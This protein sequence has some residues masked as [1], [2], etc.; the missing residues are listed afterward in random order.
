MPP[1]ILVIASL[2][3]QLSWVVFVQCHPRN[4]QGSHDPAAA[5]RCAA[6]DVGRG[7]PQCLLEGIDLHVGA[8]A[9]GQHEE[10]CNLRLGCET[11]ECA[12]GACRL[13]LVDQ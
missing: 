7:V 10:Q 5:R 13:L 9:E 11:V 4:L 3:Q 12:D 1:S 6:T 2:L 8:L